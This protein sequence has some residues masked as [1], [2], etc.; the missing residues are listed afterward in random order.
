MNITVFNGSIKCDLED[1]VSAVVFPCLY[2]VL[3]LVALI[4]NSL[5]LWVFFSIPSTSTF[6]VFLKNLVM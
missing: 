1:R 5:A 3:F 2:S 6:V 4:L